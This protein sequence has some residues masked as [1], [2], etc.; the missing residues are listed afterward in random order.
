MN[1]KK[2]KKTKST[3]NPVKEE[4]GDVRAK[5]VV[6]TTNALDT[7]VSALAVGKR[8]K[9]NPFYENE[10][11]LIKADLVYERTD[12]EIEEWQ[13]CRKDIIYFADKYCKMMTPEG[14]KHIVLRDY[15]REYLKHLM[16]K[17]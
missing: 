9:I 4:V 14:I 6:W 13:R 7:A 10:V 11:K 5:R 17:Q 8:L 1:S 15:Q 16:E 12:E 2:T 3:F